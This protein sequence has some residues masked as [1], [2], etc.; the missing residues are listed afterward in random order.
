M[1]FLYYVGKFVRN[2]RCLTMEMN[3]HCAQSYQT[4]EELRRLTLVPTQMISPGK[5]SPVLYLVQDTL[6]GGYLMTQDHIKL[7]KND[8]HNLLSFKDNYNGYLPEPA[9]MEDGEPYWTGK[10]VFSM[11][12]PDVTIMDLKKVKIK[13]GEIVDGFLEKKSLGDNSGGLV[14]QIYNSFGVNETTDFLNDSQNLVTRWITNHSFSIS[15]RDCLISNDDHKIVRNIVKDH[16]KEAKE[17]IQ[18]A[19]QGLYMPDLDDIYKAQKLEIDIVRIVNKAGEEIKKHI[20]DNASDMIKGNSF[21]KE[22]YS[23]AQGKDVNFQQIIG[24]CGQQDFQGGRIPYGFTN[25]TLPH[26]HRYDI[27]PDS[28]GFCRNSFGKGLSPSEVFFAAMSGRLSNISK[29]ITTADSGY[30]S[31]KYIKATEDLKIAYDFTV[32][33]ATNAIVQFSYGDDNYDP[34]K[35][36]HMPIK[37]FE[38]NDEKMKSTYEF[39]QN[40][41]EDRTYW[42]T[43]MTKD[44]VDELLSNPQYMEILNKEYKDMMQNRD[45]LRNVF[46]KNTKLISDAS[47]YTP[48][49]LYRMIQSNLVKFNIQSYQLSNISPLYVIEKYKAMMDSVLKYMPEKVNSVIIQQILFKSFMA[50]KRVIKE[51]RMNKL[52]FDYLI[53]TIRHKIIDSFVQP[54]EMVGVIA[55]Q[56][57]GESSTQLTM[58]AFHTAGSASGSSITRGLPRLREIIQITKKLKQQ[59]MHVYLTNEY[60]NSKENARKALAKITY[61]KLRDLLSRSEI[62]YNGANT[63][64]DDD[65][66]REFMKSYKDFVSIFGM[67]EK[68]VNC[69]SPWTLRL[70]FDKEAMM[71]RKISV[72]EIQE[73]IKESSYNDEDVECIFSDDNSSDVVMRIRIKND[74]KSEYYELMKDFEKS[75]VDLKLRGIKNIESVDPDESNI[76]KIENNGDVKDTKEWLLVTGGS[77]MVD[78]LA[79]EG[80]DATRTITNDIVEFYEIFGIEAARSL[81]YHEFMEVYEGKTVPRHVKIMVDIMTYRGKL[82]QIDRHGLNRSNDISPFSKACFEEVLNTVVKAGLF[83]ERDNMKGVSANIAMAQFCSAGTTC[84]D[85]IMDEDKLAEIEQNNFSLMMD[86]DMGE[87]TVEDVDNAYNQTY[88]ESE[89][90]EDID[91]NAFDFGFGIE[92]HKEHKLNV[93]LKKSSTDV[94]VVNNSSNSQMNGNNFG[95]INKAENLNEGELNLGNVVIEKEENQE[96]DELVNIPI[97]KH[98]EEEIKESKSKSKS[99]SKKEAVE[100]PL[101]EEISGGVKIKVKKSAIKKIKV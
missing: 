90:F 44:A 56:T 95:K 1:N 63:L 33:N 80:V 34:T 61:T 60:N 35:I 94:K 79:Q 84:F 28:R 20:Y 54:G 18:K 5:S 96:D 74:G 50:S 85:I 31:R 10:Q 4:L 3:V 81:L 57:L 52:M 6:L 13:R 76:V 66:D 100:Q 71:I 46:F 25:R 75:L 43:F 45:L 64:N 82:M 98:E 93:N 92:K 73:I 21:F 59:T 22:V 23:G 55:A 15:F 47:C 53:E 86:M 88:V 91:D 38:Y 19:Q 58:N 32:R 29:S 83:A 37:M 26:F 30:T 2:R 27:S 70:I 41:M 101:V 68:N 9:G 72:H 16:I 14:H 24:C 77:N 40:M 12:I 89:K 97:E 87:A 7:K 62:I 99:K 39:D 48:V 11:I 36:E 49:N 8:I 17:L 69:F 65:E 51:Y 67:E 78:I 42:E